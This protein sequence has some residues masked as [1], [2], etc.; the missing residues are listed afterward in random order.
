MH[1]LRQSGDEGSLK[2]AV[3]RLAA[4]GP[5]SAI[6]VEASE[7]RLDSS[8]RT[9]GPSDLALLQYGGDLVDEETADRSVTWLL[10][11]VADPGSFVSRTTPSYLVEAV[12]PA[13]CP[14]APPK[15]APGSARYRRNRSS[16]IDR[17][18]QPRDRAR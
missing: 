12:S 10:E 16:R 14:R 5:A 11:T 9:T 6:R 13:G 15:S 4:N 17:F 3:N 7:I 18:A 1:L 2:L 8:T